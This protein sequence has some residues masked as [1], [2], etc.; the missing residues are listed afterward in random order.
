MRDVVRDVVADI[1]PEELPLVDGLAVLDDTVAV[2]RLSRRRGSREP[3]GFGLGEV[4]TLV[5]PVVWLVLDHVANRAVGTAVDGMTNRARTLWRTTFRRQS[6][7]VTVPPLSREQ[8]A[9][10]RQRVL[11]TAVQRGLPEE[12][13]TAIADAVVARLVLTDDGDEPGLEPAP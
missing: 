1:A 4:F 9:E 5:T 3:L 7:P 12:R 13:A 2:R 6:E 10:V 11:E 8:L